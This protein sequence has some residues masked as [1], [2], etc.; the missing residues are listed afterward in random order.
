[1]APQ[2]EAAWI[3]EAKSPLI[4]EAAPYNEPGPNEIVIKVRFH[5]FHQNHDNGV[6]DTNAYYRIKQ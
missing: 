4:V 1:M 6:L 2:N 5:L 3:K